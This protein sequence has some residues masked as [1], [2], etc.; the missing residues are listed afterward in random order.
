MQCKSDCTVCCWITGKAD[1]SQMTH[2]QLKKPPRVSLQ[3]LSQGLCFS[4]GFSVVGLKEQLE[5]KSSIFL[6]REKSS[7]QVGL[8][9]ILVSVLF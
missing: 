5:S 3:D 4:R 8:G 7:R 2:L 6:M 9:V 1:F